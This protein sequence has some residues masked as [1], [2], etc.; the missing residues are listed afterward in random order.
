MSRRLAGA[1]YCTDG[2]WFFSV[3]LGKDA[4]PQRPSFLLAT[5]GT[6][7][8]AEARRTFL[9][10][11]IGQ[12]RSAQH[13]DMIEPV[14]R[15]AASLPDA[16]LDLVRTLVDGLVRGTEYRAQTAQPGG[17]SITFEQFATKWTSNELAREFRR[18]VKE[19]AHHDNAQRLKRHVFPIVYRPTI[20]TE[21]TTYLGTRIGDIPMTDFTVDHADYVL[22][23]STLPEGSVHNLASLIR[24][25]CNLAVVPAKLLKASPLPRGWAPGPNPKKEKS[26]LFP[27]EEA[28]LLALTEMPLVR[29]VLFGFMNREGTRKENAVTIEWDQLTL[30]GLPDGAGHI[31]L[32]MTKNGRG[33]S[34]ALDPG[35][36]EALR[37]WRTI[38]PSK[39]YVFPASAVPGH[40]TAER[41][42]YVDKLAE[43]LRDG[44]LA[45]G[46]TRPKLFESSKHRMRLRAHD[47][48]GTFV[49]ISLANDKS[50]HWVATR[51]GHRSTIMISS[52]RTVATTAAELNLG[53]LAPM[54]LSIPEL[55]NLTTAST[56]GGRVIHVRFGQ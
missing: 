6:R 20:V 38:C 45:A 26:Y 39:Q 36:A 55:A 27:K 47:L 53:P 16:R 10:E 31:V 14:C 52:Y 28:R 48:R 44:L 17:S 3:Y 24:R 46:V 40:R 33:G 18:R 13:S 54:H 29:R 42:M 9:V 21:A 11:I 50:E 22:A 8:E 51:T 5:C 15:Q 32:D 43:Q 56:A 2:H 23:Q 34:W 35:T 7:E 49:T 1:V 41:P 37:R 4:K 19:V 12:L 30:D 25:I